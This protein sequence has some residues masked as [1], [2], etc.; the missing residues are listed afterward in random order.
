MLLGPTAYPIVG[1]V[2]EVMVAAVAAGGQGGKICL[3]E[4]FYF[5]CG[6]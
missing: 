2:A 1:V 3:H 6:Y 5:D 4:R